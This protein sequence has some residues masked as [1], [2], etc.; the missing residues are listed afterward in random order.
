M[1][2]TRAVISI[3]FEEVARLRRPDAALP[4]PREIFAVLAKARRRCLLAV[5]VDWSAIV[6]LVLANRDAAAI[7]TLTPTAETVL[8][9]GVLA[10]A[11]H[12]GF[13]LGQLEKYRAVERAA[14]DLLERNA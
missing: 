8:T 6:L 4:D 14:Q 10:V 2:H 1:W 13:R 7:L 3:L 9:L 12:S 5:L 11:V